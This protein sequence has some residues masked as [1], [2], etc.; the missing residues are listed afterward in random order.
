MFKLKSVRA[1]SKR[2]FSVPWD[3]M[4]EVYPV[5]ELVK[6]DLNAKIENVI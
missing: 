2:R 6:N 3:K 4:R 1:I 5:N